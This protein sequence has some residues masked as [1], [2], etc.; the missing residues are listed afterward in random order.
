MAD[1]GFD[2]WLIAEYSG[3]ATDLPIVEWIQY[4]ELLCEFCKIK[5]I[6]WILL[7]CLRAGALAV[8]WQLTKM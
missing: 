5:K 7:L 4:V 1:R 6:K 2:I 8:Y 3:A